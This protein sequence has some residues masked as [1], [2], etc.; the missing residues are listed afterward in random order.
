MA[1]LV[2]LAVNV[3]LTLAISGLPSSAEAAGAFAGAL[4]SATLLAALVTWLIA[5][6][7][8]QGWRFPLL[9][10]LALP[11]YLVVRVLAE[12]GGAAG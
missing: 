2:W 1:T 9:V 5:R 10:L 8:P 3:V 7:S 11:F 4:V 6:R 12:A